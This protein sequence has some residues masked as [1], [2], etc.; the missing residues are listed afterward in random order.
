MDICWIFCIVVEYTFLIYCWISAS[1]LKRGYWTC[2]SRLR[3]L[4]STVFCCWAFSCSSNFWFYFCRFSVSWRLQGFSQYSWEQGCFFLFQPLQQ[5]HG[6]DI[7][8]TTRNAYK[9]ELTRHLSVASVL[10]VDGSDFFQSF[11]LGIKRDDLLHQHWL[12]CFLH[13]ETVRECLKSLPHWLWSISSAGAAE[14]LCRMVLRKA[15]LNWTLFSSGASCWSA[16]AP[17]LSPQAL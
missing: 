15:S 10:F 7:S 2:C 14:H 8:P 13:R 1:L 16:T 6:L 3:D 9:G 5:G 12:I 11:S 17:S 4:Y